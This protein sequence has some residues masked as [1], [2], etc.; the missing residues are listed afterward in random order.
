M[1][2]QLEDIKVEKFASILMMVLALFKSFIAQRPAK[3]YALK[4]E[5]VPEEYRK[6]FL[7]TFYENVQEEDRKL[8]LATFYAMKLE[9]VSEEDKKKYPEIFYAHVP[10]EDRKQC[11]A[12]F[13]AMKQDFIKK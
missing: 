5:N 2:K 4:L 9:N 1:W 6:Q 10:E 12:T 7:E 11:L 13:Y 3:C 8:C